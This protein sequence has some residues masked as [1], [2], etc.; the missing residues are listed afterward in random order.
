MRED[1]AESS[2]A[3]SGA[4]LAR[5]RVVAGTASIAGVL[6]AGCLASG[7]PEETAS[8]ES[9]TSGEADAQS[10]A[11]DRALTAAADEP[12]G[13]REVTMRPEALEF[14]PQLV[15]IG[16]GGTVTWVNGDSDDH[17]VVAFETRVPERGDRWE[18]PQLA[19]GETY[20]RT[21][22][23]PGVYDYGSTSSESNAIGRVVVGAPDLAS[24]PALEPDDD[25]EADH[26][27]TLRELNR[28]TL[29]LEIDADCNC[30]E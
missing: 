19:S 26:E 29:S 9:P 27:A 17:D 1:T 11:S 20:E 28:M 8:A 10:T 2:A 14:D 30:P 4:S 21:F 25:L 16:R 13:T 23:E 5:R 7:R 15:W 6:T 24:E 3:L 18:S 12:A 22:E